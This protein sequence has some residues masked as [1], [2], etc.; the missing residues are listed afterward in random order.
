FPPTAVMAWLGMTEFGV[1]LVVLALAA[2]PAGVFVL[3]K[4]MGPAPEAE[5][6]ATRFALWSLVIVLAAIIVTYDVGVWR[7]YR[8]LAPPLLLSLFTLPPCPSARPLLFGVLLMQAL[9]FPPF[10][11]KAK[12]LLPPPAKPAAADLRPYLAFDP[13]AGRWG[14]T[15]LLG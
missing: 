6:P 7:D 9:A 8:V 13:A 4:R 12:E 11:P 5:R 2:F 3:A 14:N 1:Q 15:V 10:R